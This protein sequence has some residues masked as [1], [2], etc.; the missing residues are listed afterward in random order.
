LDATTGQAVA[1][2]GSAEPW[3]APAMDHARRTG[4]PA[5]AKLGF[6][7]RALIIKQLAIYLNEHKDRLYQLSYQTGA[8]LA[9]SRID[10]DGGIGVAFTLSSKARRELPTGTVLPDGAPE[11]LSR[12]ASFGGSHLY[13]SRGGVFW[14]VNAFNFPV[15]GLLEKFVPAFLAGMPVIAKPA[16][17]T[18]HVAQA[19]VELMAQSGLL[20]PG[21]LQ[22]LAGPAR[23]FWDQLDLRD[24]VALTGSA[25][26]AAVFRAKQPVVDGTVTLAAESDSLNAAILGPKSTP[27]TPEFTAFV[28]AAVTELTAKA[29][30]KCTAIRRLIVPEPLADAVVQAVAQRVAAKVTLG[31][32]RVAGVTMGPLVSVGQQREVLDAIGRLVAGGGQVVLGGGVPATVRLDHGVTGPAP[33]GAFVE[34][35]LLRF[36]NPAA[37]AA[38][39]VEAFGPVASMVAYST[40]DQAVE[41]ANLGGGSLVATVASADPG[42]VA[43]VG[44]GI[45]PFHGRIH[46]LDGSTARSSTGHGSP[47]P[48]LTHGGPGRAGGGEELGGIRAV[49]HLMHRIALQGSP[50]NLTALT[51]QFHTGAKR[52]LSAVHPFRRSLAD[53]R[54]GDSVTGG[55]RLVTLADI[56]HFAQFTGD[57]FYAHMDEAAAKANPFFPGR[58]AH[59][60]LL[61]SWAAGLFV[62][63]APGPVLAN[64]GLDN[65]RFLNPVSPGDSIEVELT[66]KSI[67]PRVTDPYGEVAWAT[68]ITNQRGEQV[69]SYDVLTLVASV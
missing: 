35:T 15:W 61:L 50:D 2:V 3:V 47:M 34:P 51:G 21:T 63:P 12:D 17:P 5:L 31:D 37:H 54:V 23:E 69:A 8:T 49:K 32:P 29:G 26:T 22:L 68:T 6:H 46:L 20:P 36:A 45:G 28:A 59:G 7:Q 33:H 65:A 40:T 66:C 11:P 44:T 39:R 16:T 62:D 9:D 67:K 52:R 14:A 42:F 41:L 57:T 25:T 56:E 38:H 43:Q 60:Y 55:P 24:Y 1:L 18:A 27:D 4:V 48:H 10:V 58:V 19:C 30:Q 53:L 64:F 13:V